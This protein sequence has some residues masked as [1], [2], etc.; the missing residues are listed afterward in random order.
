VQCE[1]LVEAALHERVDTAE[2]LVRRLTRDG[3]GVA[4]VIGRA[5]RWPRTAG[6]AEKPF[7]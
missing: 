5:A 6:V 3:D 4:V 1:Q 7:S 2:Q